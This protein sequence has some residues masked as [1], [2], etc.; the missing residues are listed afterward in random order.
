M[1]KQS[2]YWVVSFKILAVIYNS[3]DFIIKSV[4]RF[5]GII[6]LLN[7]VRV[8]VKSI[9]LKAILSILTTFKKCR[10]ILSQH[11]RHMSRR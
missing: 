9:K 10:V 2:D 11:K 5:S 1:T 4:K 6:D 3:G 8:I 7:T